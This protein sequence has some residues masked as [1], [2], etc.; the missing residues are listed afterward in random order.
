L[1]RFGEVTGLVTNYAKSQVAPIKC[2]DIELQDVFQPFPAKLTN[3]PM[4]Y[5]GLPLSLTRL[6]RIHLQYL[7][8]KVFG[9]LVPWLGKHAS[10]ARRTVLVKAVLFWDSSWL[11]GGRPKDISPLIYKIF[12]KKNCIVRKALE[13]NF[14]VS[15]ICNMDSPWSISPNFPTFGRDSQLFMSMKRSMIQSLG[16]L[17]HMVV[18]PG[19]Q[20]TTCNL[21]VSQTPPCRP[22]C[23][24]HGIPPNEIFS[25][26][27]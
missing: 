11:D 16:S 14:W 8:D 1:D 25:L 24:S 3:F 26:S 19:A 2:H 10:M 15:Q 7:E 20:H 6:K 13:N 27:L 5:L 17:L 23:G 12:K 18:T 4:R 22:W 21:R 9:K